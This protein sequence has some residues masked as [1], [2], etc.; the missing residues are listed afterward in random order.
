MGNV[1]TQCCFGSP[2]SLGNRTTKVPL[3]LI[4]VAVDLTVKKVGPVTLREL[5]MLPLTERAA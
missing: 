2:L 3:Q 4:L 5:P 1:S